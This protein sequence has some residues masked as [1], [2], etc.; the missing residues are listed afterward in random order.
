MT[1]IIGTIAFVFSI[2][3]YIVGLVAQIIKNYKYKE[4]AVDG[5]LKGLSAWLI[6]AIFTSHTLWTLYVWLKHDHYLMYAFTIQLVLG[7]VIAIQ[8]IYYKRKILINSLNE[9]MTINKKTC[10]F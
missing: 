9:K 8:V 6:F 1:E 10:N 3:V 4:V 2:L 7:I 5:L